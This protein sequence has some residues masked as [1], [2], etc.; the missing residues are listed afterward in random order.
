MPKDQQVE[1]QLAKMEKLVWDSLDPDTKDN[2]RQEQ[3]DEDE[4]EDSD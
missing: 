3:E 4:E 1:S 2:E